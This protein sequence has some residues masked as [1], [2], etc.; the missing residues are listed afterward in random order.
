MMKL[1]NVGSHLYPGIL[2]G[3]FQ[4]TSDCCY[5]CGCWMGGSRSGTRDEHDPTDPFGECPGNPYDAEKLRELLKSMT[6]ECA[7]LRKDKAELQK[8]LDAAVACATE[9]IIGR[10]RKSLAVALDELEKLARHDAVEGGEK[11]VRGS[12]QANEGS[13]Q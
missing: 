7:Y 11:L 4:N 13:A 2:D 9:R 12:D 10:A 5:G 3:R 6:D 1:H 8:R